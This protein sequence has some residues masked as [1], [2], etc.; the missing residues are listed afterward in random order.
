MQCDNANPNSAKIINLFPAC[1]KAIDIS[2]RRNT[3]NII[4]IGIMIIAAIFKDGSIVI[5][6]LPYQIKLTSWLSGERLS[7]SDR[8]LT[9]RG[10]QLTI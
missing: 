10:G 4:R 5:F 9:P 6:P 7:L 2:G 3:L 1:S 8:L